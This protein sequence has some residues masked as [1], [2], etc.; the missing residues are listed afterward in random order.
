MTNEYAKYE[1][2]VKD[3]KKQK[4]VS[5]SLYKF[6]QAIINKNTDSYSAN[7]GDSSE[8]VHKL[9]RLMKKDDIATQSLQYLIPANRRV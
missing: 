4:E 5:L 7:F 9:Y 2:L 6:R 1:G 3:N 8:K